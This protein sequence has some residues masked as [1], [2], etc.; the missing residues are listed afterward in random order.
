MTDPASPDQR[1][2]VATRNRKKTIEIREMLRGV[3]EVVD[4]NE[5]EAEGVA[6]P[7]VEETGSTFSENATLKAVGISREV[8]GLVLADDSGLEVDGLGGEPGVWSSSYGGEEGNHL[9]NNAR[10]ERELPQVP[11]DQRSGRFRCVMVLAREGQALAEFA[12]AVEGRLIPTPRGSEG[13]GY[14]PYFIPEGYEKT[15]AELGGEI[16]NSMSHRGR[17]LAQVVDWMRSS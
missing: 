8:A 5:L 2:I 9:K 1:L 16:K 15:F 17:A 6:L 11:E 14:D 10:L 7:E 4:V 3:C 13:F 12:G